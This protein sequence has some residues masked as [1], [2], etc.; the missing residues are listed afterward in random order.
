MEGQVPFDFGDRAEEKNKGIWI[1]KTANIAEGAVLK[2]PCYVG[3][4]AS[5]G[6]N[7]HIPAQTLIG[8]NSLVNQ[9]IASGMYSA[10][11]MLI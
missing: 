10:G 3:E 5:I 1:A 9:A 2:S 8:A 7:A 6:K 11:T 4:Y